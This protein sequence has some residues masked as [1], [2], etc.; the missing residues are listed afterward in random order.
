LVA[1]IY[2]LL[3]VCPPLAEA[4]NCPHRLSRST[5]G[6]QTISSEVSS[7]RRFRIRRGCLARNF[8]THRFFFL[9]RHA[10]FIFSVKGNFLS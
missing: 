7:S 9:R 6:A 5:R 3:S 4:G 2:N 8:F 10:C 1:C